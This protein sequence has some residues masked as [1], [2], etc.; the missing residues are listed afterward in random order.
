MNEIPHIVCYGEVLW[1][2]FIDT[3][4][5]GG[6]P[7]NLAIRLQSLGA[8]SELVSAIGN[9]QEGGETLAGQVFEQL[10]TTDI[11]GKKKW[12]DTSNTTQR[13][14]CGASVQIAG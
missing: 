6:A 2:I 13:D 1:D 10:R 5:L 9:D 3:K 12:K 14:G 8:K 11:T 4:R 7:L